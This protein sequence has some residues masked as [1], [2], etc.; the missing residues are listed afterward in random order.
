MENLYAPKGGEQQKENRGLLAFSNTF[1]R[2]EAIYEALMAK[3]EPIEIES[4]TVN[5]VGVVEEEL[6]IFC[7]KEKSQELKSIVSLLKL[8]PQFQL[9]EAVKSVGTLF[10]KEKVTMLNNVINPHT[11]TL[12]KNAKMLFDPNYPASSSRRPLLYTPFALSK[13]VRSDI[14]KIGRQSQRGRKVDIRGALSRS[15]KFGERPQ[16]AKDREMN[17]QNTK[18]RVPP[19]MFEKQLMEQAY[20]DLTNRVGGREFLS[21]DQL[22]SLKE[23]NEQIRNDYMDPSLL[24]MEELENRDYGIRLFR[25]A[26]PSGAS[27]RT[28]DGLD[29]CLVALVD[30]KARAALD[31]L[32]WGEMGDFK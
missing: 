5:V 24:L 11:R 27:K 4:K 8:S 7:P 25:I 21:H 29:D 19:I 31:K 13:E 1:T 2:D 23:D 26:A 15:V 10:S 17:S 6:I 30:Q 3:G 28:V 20:D 32:K 12:T 22:Y 14:I 16:G 18:K 9:L